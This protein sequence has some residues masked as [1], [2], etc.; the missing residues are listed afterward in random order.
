MKIKV[1]SI[2]AFRNIENFTFNARDITLI[3]GNNMKGKTNTL[4]AIN[5]CLTGIDLNGSNDNS[6]NIP[7]SKDRAYVRI[8][9]DSG[10]IERIAKLE[11]NQVNSTIIINGKEFGAK[12][13]DKEIDKLLGISEISAFDTQKV[14]V[15]RLLLNPMLYRSIAPKDLRNWL[16]NVLFGNIKE[17]QIIKQSNLSE[18]SKKLLLNELDTISLAELSKANSSNKKKCEE[19]IKQKD[20]ILDYLHSKLINAYNEELENEK[21]SLKK[22]LLKYSELKVA[23]DEGALE[24]NKFY[25]S[26][27]SK[28]TLD[29][30]LLERN[31][32]EDSYKEVC[33]PRINGNFPIQNGSTA[34]LIVVSVMFINLLETLTNT[35]SFPKLIDEGETLDKQMLES[36]RES[37]SQLFITK[38][39]YE[40]QEGVKVE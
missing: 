6:L 29:I 8:E 34:E 5:W 19:E 2:I 30:V 28:R 36:L 4:N 27:L 38:V 23:I 26:V 11:D 1:V 22:N 20:I 33:Y 15:K 17:S 39:S 24:L 31:K 12:T 16:I 18:V 14:K 9:L 7:K 37:N 32:E 21:K 35:K 3:S 25:A 40:L 10:V 13:A